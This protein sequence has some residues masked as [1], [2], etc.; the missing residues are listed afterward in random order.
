MHASLC[1]YDYVLVLYVLFSVLLLSSTSTF[2]TWTVWCVSGTIAIQPFGATMTLM[3][4]RTVL[5][6]EWFKSWDSQFQAMVQWP[7]CLSL[8]A[9]KITHHWVSH[10]SGITPCTYE[11]EA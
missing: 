2:P 10:R 7:G 8:L 4:Y 11:H 9:T 6:A 1:A 5:V 3:I